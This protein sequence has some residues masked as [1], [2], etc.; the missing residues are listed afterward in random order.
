MRG[1]VT[2]MVRGQQ[3]QGNTIHKNLMQALVLC[4]GDDAINL[5]DKDGS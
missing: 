4:R 3:K 5:V 1:E 2:D